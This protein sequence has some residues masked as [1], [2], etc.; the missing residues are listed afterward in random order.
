VLPIGSP[1]RVLLVQPREAL[2]HATARQLEGAGFEPIVVSDGDAAVR[3]A[4]TDPPSVVLLDLTLPVIDGWC[5]L[6]TLGSR[7]GP[8]VVVYAPPGD[9]ARAV[10]LGAA[11]C[12]HDR[13]GIVPALRRLLTPV[14]F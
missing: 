1:G 7:S 10:L 3:L 5:V 4:V 13:G 9:A 8:P 2:A 6:S 14:P 11:A 12:L